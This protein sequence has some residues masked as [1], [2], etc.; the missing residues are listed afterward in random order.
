MKQILGIVAVWWVLLWSFWVQAYFE[1]TFR[2]VIED[3]TIQVSLTSWDQLCLD[4]MAWLTK[5]LQQVSVDVSSATD[6]AKNTQGYDRQYWEGVLHEVTT[7]KES[8]SHVQHQ[9]LLAMSDFEQEL[10]VRVKWIVWYY[11]LSHTEEIERKLGQW[12]NLLTRLIITWNKE[13]YVFV[14]T[15][16]DIRERELMFL[17]RI[18]QSSDFVELIPPLKRRISLQSVQK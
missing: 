9:I 13:Q 17:H 8:L 14:R 1:H 4:Y 10:F 12:R 6:N 16:M 7:K 18:K 3:D 2:C 11:L 15:Q 5:L